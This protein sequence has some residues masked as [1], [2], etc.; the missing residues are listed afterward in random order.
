MPEARNRRLVWAV[1]VP[2]RVVRSSALSI[3]VI[4]LNHRT[5]PLELLERTTVSPE[6]LAQGA[7]RPRR[8]RPT[9][10]RRWCS[11][12]ATAPRSTPSPSASTAPSP[13]S[14]TSC[15]TWPTWRPRTCS[16]HLYSQHDEAAVAHLFSVAAGLD[17]AVLGEHEILGQV[18]SAWS[19]AQQEGAAR[20]ALNL[21][22]RHAARDR[23]AGPHR[24]GHRPLDGVGV[25][26]PPSRWRPSGSARS[27]GAR[28]S[29]SAPARWARASS[30]R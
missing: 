15:A 20:S 1:L 12:R 30:P 5:V 16:R 23:Q 22:F 24:D 11:R 17:S 4:G 25:A 9:S 27:P 2:I 6:A 26:T 29:S 18:R 13:T 19:V 28:C 3:V 8:P 14:A 21:L 10:A 7:A